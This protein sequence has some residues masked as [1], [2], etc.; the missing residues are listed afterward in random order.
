LTPASN[1]KPGGNATGECGGGLRDGNND[2]DIWDGNPSLLPASSGDGDDDVDIGGVARLALGANTGALNPGG[3]RRDT[4]PLVDWDIDDG[5]VL[6]LRLFV[7]DGVP[8]GVRCKGT[9]VIVELIRDDDDNDDD[10]G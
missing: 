3:G 9:S 8:D 5:V 1:S 2:N 10:D 7:I 6:L 4:S